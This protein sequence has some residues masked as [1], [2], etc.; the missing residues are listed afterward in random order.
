MILDEYGEFADALTIPV[1]FSDD[2]VVLGDTIDLGG[3]TNYPGDGEPFYCVITIDTAVTSAGAA[4]V[5]FKLQSAAADVASGST[6]TSPTT[7]WA[8]DVIGKATLVAGYRV[9][10]FAL[11]KGP[12]QRYLGVVGDVGTADLT[13]GKVNAF[14]T[15]DVSKYLAFPNAI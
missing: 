5:Q 2:D 12:Y 4:T 7:H 10:A 6:F 13:A 14:L 9:A 15:K 3:T 1:L 8:G 11:P